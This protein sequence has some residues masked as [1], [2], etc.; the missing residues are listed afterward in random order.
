MTNQL[1]FKVVALYPFRGSFTDDL[2]FDPGQEIDV[3]TEYEDGWLFG[4]YVDAE[5]VPRQGNFPSTF[6]KS[7]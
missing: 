7:K 4:S 3:F 1:L 2:E 5:G 6:T